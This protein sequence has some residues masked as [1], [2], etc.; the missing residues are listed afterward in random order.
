MAAETAE[1]AS[2]RQEVTAARKVVSGHGVGKKRQYKPA[3]STA[4]KKDSANREDGEC[5]PQKKKLMLSNNDHADRR[6]QQHDR[7]EPEL[8]EKTQ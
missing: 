8:V 4:E 7:R 6:I 5:V 1:K 2:V 3:A